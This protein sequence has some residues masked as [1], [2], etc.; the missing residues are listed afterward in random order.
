MGGRGGS[1]AGLDPPT[2]PYDPRCAVPAAG[3]PAAV[4]AL[5]ATFDTDKTRPLAWRRAR[6]E[7]GGKVVGGCFVQCVAERVSKRVLEW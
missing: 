7:A 4:K 2:S 5:R 1:S 3:I 6:R